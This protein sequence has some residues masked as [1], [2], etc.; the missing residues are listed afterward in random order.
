M[1]SLLALFALV[2]AAIA[3]NGLE[4]RWY[5][6]SNS[7]T[8]ASTQRHRCPP[9][10]KRCSSYPETATM[11]TYTTVTTCPLTTSSGSA[12]YTTLTTSTIVV[13]TCKG[14]CHKTSNPPPSPPPKQTIS[15]GTAP[16]PPSPPIKTTSL[17]TAP[18][19][20]P[21]PPKTTPLI[22]TAPLPPKPS[23]ETTVVTSI[24]PHPQSPIYSNV[25]VLLKNGE[26]NELRRE[27][28]TMTKTKTESTPALSTTKSYA[29]STIFITTTTC[30]GEQV[31]DANEICLLIRFGQSR[32]KL[33]P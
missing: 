27:Q 16:K 31:L 33:S 12:Y 30:P 13:T 18:P 3:A 7:T 15:T 5:P 26:K 32:R 10:L 22:G 6:K 11:T 9:I 25:C 2:G 17:G 21:S 23:H 19:P 28:T 29:T 4:N 24:L 20:Q 8:Y 14:G 1:K